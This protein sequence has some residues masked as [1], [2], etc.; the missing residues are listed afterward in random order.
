MEYFIVPGIICFILTTLAFRS[1]LGPIWLTILG[2]GTASI[3][4]LGIALL[5]SSGWGGIVGLLVIVGLFKLAPIFI[6]IVTFGAVI[7]TSLKPDRSVLEKSVD[8]ADISKSE[9][10]PSAVQL[11]FP[12]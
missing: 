11:I 10:T 7:G 1:S 9:Q 8:E 2:F 3:C 6:V 12:S 5:A 4:A